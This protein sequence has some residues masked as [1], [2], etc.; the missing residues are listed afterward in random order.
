VEH[1]AGCRLDLRNHAVEL[2]FGAHQ[3]IDMFDRRDRRILRGRRARDRDQCLAG[4]VRDEMKV[5]ETA[6]AMRHGGTRLWTAGEK[7][8]A[9]RRAQAGRDWH[10][11]TSKTAIH[12]DANV[13]PIR[14]AILENWNSVIG[15]ERSVES[16]S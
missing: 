1:D 16:F 5:K 9:L 2:L 10:G 15:V 12:I 11:G 6:G 14:V 13:Q 8:M 4:C 3:R 7:A